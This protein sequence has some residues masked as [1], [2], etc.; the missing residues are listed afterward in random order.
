MNLEELG[1][2]FAPEDLEW[3]VQQAGA[4]DG[5]PW[6]RVLV[7][8][9]NRAIMNRLDDVCGAENWQNELKEISNGSFICGLSIKIGDEWVTKWDGCDKSD[10]EPVKGAISGAMKRSAVQWK[11]GRYLYS[12]DA[13]FAIVSPDGKHYQP[14]KDGKYSAFKWNPPALPAWALPAVQGNKKPET[15]LPSGALYLIES[16]TTLEELVKTWSALSKQEQSDFRSV[17][18]TKKQELTIGGKK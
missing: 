12:L 4:K 11:I 9:T 16:C 8:V 6:A 5:K 13:G 7:Y 1:K 15:T 3:R 18:D 17:K 2:P 10:I 14:A